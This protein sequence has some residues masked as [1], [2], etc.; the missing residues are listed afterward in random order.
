M[1][2]A[3]SGTG[4]SCTR[5]LASPYSHMLGWIL[6]VSK[7]NEFRKI[8]SSEGYSNSSKFCIRSVLGA[9]LEGLFGATVAF[10]RRGADTGLGDW[11]LGVCTPQP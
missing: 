3:P 11:A 4:I 1:M 2:R 7:V 6:Y 8:T 10:T 9:S 5:K